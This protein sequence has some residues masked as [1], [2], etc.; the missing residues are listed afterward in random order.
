MNTKID[1]K[2]VLVGLSVGVLV[3]LSIGAAF[4][5]DTVG[6]YQ[7]AGTGNHGLIIDTATGEVWRAYFRS[8]GGRTDG[9]FFTP[10]VGEKK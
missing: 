1:I 9:D 7:I 5:T 10:K 2:S 6:R 8:N 3:T 4:S